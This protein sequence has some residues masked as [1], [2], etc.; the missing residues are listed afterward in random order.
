ML[1]AHNESP[2]RHA[3]W[4]R[5]AAGVAIT[6]ALTAPALGQVLSTSLAPTLLRSSTAGKIVV[7]DRASST[8]TVIDIATDTVAATLD[9]PAADNPAEPMYV[10]Y[11]PAGHRFFI[12]DRANDRVVAFDANTLEPV[13]EAPAGM[14][15]FHMWGSAPKG[16]LWVNNDVEKTTS[17]IDVWTLETIATV[18]TPADLVVMGGKP[19]DVILS[20][21]GDYAYVTVLG[22]D[23]PMDWVVQYDTTTFLEIGRAPVGD[24]PH[25]SVTL[26]NNDLYVPCQGDG[27]VYVLDRDTLAPVTVLAVPGAHGAGLTFTGRYFYATNISGGGVDA[28]WTIDT[29][30]NQVVGSP[31]DAPYAAPHNIAVTGNG[32]KLY[33]THSGMNDKVSVY[34]MFGDDPMPVYVGE[35]TTGDNPFGLAWVPPVSVA[36]GFRR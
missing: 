36:S 29:D 1:T 7:A 18:P 33:V 14:G 24:D 23:G 32:Q 19:H 11:S 5:R 9:F 20:P 8:A 17:V 4:T 30:T 10:W 22:V 25:L 34:Q 13:A 26:R 16:Q 21:E 27:S 2:H 6:L 31:V 15:V 35:V 28:L 12:G 3:S